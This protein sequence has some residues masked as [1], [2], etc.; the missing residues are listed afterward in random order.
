[1]QQPPRDPGRHGSPFAAAFLSF[2][3]PG[4]GQ[5]YAGAVRRG[6]ALAAPLALGLVVLAVVLL[7]A[8]ARLRQTPPRPGLPRIRRQSPCLRRVRPPPC[9]LK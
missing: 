7:D 9:R 4:L 2:V 8:S 1:M 6:L 5:V 3:F